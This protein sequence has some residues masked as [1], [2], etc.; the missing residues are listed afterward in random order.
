[1]LRFI[2]LTALY[3]L[4]SWYAEAFIAGPDQ[5]TLI[6]PSAGVAYAAVL[7]YGWRWAWFVPVAVLL[8]DAVFVEVPVSFLPFSV[9]SNTLGALAGG[10][11]VQ[12]SGIVPRLTVKSGFTMMRGGLVM[13]FVSGAI[14]T[15]GL[16]YS[17]MVPAQEVWPALFK[18]SMGD[19]LGIIGLTPTLLLLAAPGSNNP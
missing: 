14:G 8:S 13:V 4:G 9:L 2:L 6:W 11:V 16:V 19:L 5:V 3:M 12:R 18:W 10:W 15:W 17:G 1:M 7:R